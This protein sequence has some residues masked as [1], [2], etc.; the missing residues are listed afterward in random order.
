MAFL[1]GKADELILDRRAVA[2]ART[3]DFA[4]IHCRARD[5]FADDA[6]GFRICVYNMAWNLRTVLKIILGMV[7]REGQGMFFAR[8]DFELVP[9]DCFPFD[10]RR[11]AGFEARKFHAG[12]KKRRRKP[13][14]G[15]K[16][17]GPRLVGDVA[18]EDR[19]FEIGSCGKDQGFA[20]PFFVKARG[21]TFHFAVFYFKRDD[22]G[23]NEAQV[24]RFLQHFL[25]QT[26]IVF[27][28]CLHAFA[29]HGNA[30]ALI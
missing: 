19:R 1:I 22:F 9:V 18:D 30:L 6:V 2:R 24:R 13:F 21:K 14:G 28:V 25:H 11:R 20:L 8:L 26:M 17:V 12:G 3:M 7:G 5:V 23:L 16:S 10:A 27:A 15:K 4:R 29:L